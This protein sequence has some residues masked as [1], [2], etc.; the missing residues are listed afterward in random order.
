MN[1]SPPAKVVRL[2]SNESS[3]SSSPITY[4][5]RIVTKE[6]LKKVEPKYPFMHEAMTIT[7]DHLNTVEYE[8]VNSAGYDRCLQAYFD[9]REIKKPMVAPS[10]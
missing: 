10:F 1:K 5:K 7:G 2:K 8:S 6:S 3:P 4:V 9:W